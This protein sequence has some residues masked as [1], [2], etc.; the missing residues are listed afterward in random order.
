MSEPFIMLEIDP[1]HLAKHWSQLLPPAQGLIAQITL[2][3]RGLMQPPRLSLHR[4][5]IEL[6]PD[7]PALAI[8]R[9]ILSES[10]Q[11]FLC[12]LETSEALIR[13]GENI[14]QNRSRFNGYRILPRG[15]FC[16][17]DF[18]GDDIL[19]DVLDPSAWIEAYARVSHDANEDF[20]FEMNEICRIA[21]TNALQFEPIPSIP[22]SVIALEQKYLQA[23]EAMLAEKNSGTDKTRLHILPPLERQRVTARFMKPFPKPVQPRD[24]DD[25]SSSSGQS[26]TFTSKNERQSNTLE[27]D[28]EIARKEEKKYQ[29]S[30]DIR[31]FIRRLIVR[32]IDWS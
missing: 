4:D 27:I 12:K 18:D 21:L 15:E 30:R 31:C 24:D 10:A 32:M 25:E 29:R 26:S 6:F 14:E 28:L 13:C 17:F 16:L 5:R 7:C 1:N 9:H 20:K 23:V 11:D 8:P 3:I 19:T 22:P 2:I